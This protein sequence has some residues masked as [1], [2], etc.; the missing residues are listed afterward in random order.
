MRQRLSPL[1]TQHARQC[2]TFS[3]CPWAL[4][5]PGR[6]PFHCWPA[7]PASRKQAK[8]S[9]NEQKVKNSHPG[10]PTWVC[11]P[12]HPW[13]IYGPPTASRYTPWSVHTRHAV[14]DCST[15]TVLNGTSTRAAFPGKKG[16]LFPLRNNPP[17]QGK[18]GQSVKETRH[19]ESPR[20]RTAG[21][22]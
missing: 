1:Y 6:D 14:I 18:Q 13:A 10:Y 5:R 9:R 8:T 4:G 21:I 3:S 15:M 12:V 22:S 7:L 20:T 16:G 11:L 19:R 17:S 2:C